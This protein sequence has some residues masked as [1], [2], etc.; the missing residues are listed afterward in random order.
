MSINTSPTSPE[1]VPL[2]FG[3]VHP[4]S[5]EMPFGERQ[6]QSP[7]EFGGYSPG[8]LGHH[9][10]RGRPL[11]EARFPRSWLYCE[12]HVFA[13]RRNWNTQRSKS[14]SLSL[15]VIA[16]VRDCGFLNNNGE[17]TKPPFPANIKLIDSFCWCP[18]LFSFSPDY[19]SMRK[20]LLTHLKFKADVIYYFIFVHSLAN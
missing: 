15:S 9:F 8:Q 18:Q 14:T 1:T 13:T 19:F 5:V 4:L 20:N 16:R 11:W 6:P 2:D 3:P 7:P 10:H 17:C 12:P